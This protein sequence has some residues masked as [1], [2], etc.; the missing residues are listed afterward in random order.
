MK[1]TYY[2]IFDRNHILSLIDNAH[3]IAKE[4]VRGRRNQ[5]EAV[6]AILKVTLYGGNCYAIGQCMPLWKRIPY[7]TDKI[8][9]GDAIYRFNGMNLGCSKFCDYRQLLDCVIVDHVTKKRIIGINDERVRP[10]QII[11]VCR[12]DIER[13]ATK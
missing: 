11:C 12:E 13:S 7:I 4:S 10:E 1:N 6:P 2:T 8:K 3:D 5:L 9:R